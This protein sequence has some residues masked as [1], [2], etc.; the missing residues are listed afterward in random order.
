MKNNLFNI[1]FGLFTL[2]ILLFS[3]DINA[4]SSVSVYDELLREIK[5]NSYT[6]NLTAATVRR[7]SNTT[8]YTYTTHGVGRVD[9][10]RYASAVTATAQVAF[11]DRNK[12]KGKKDVQKLF[13][14][15]SGRTIVAY[16]SLESWGKS[17]EY[18]SD[19]Q[20]HKERYGYYL[21]GKYNNGFSSTRYAISFFK[22]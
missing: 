8:N 10:G 1:C 16:I 22:Q 19:I 5:T 2:T 11:S 21:T 9:G 6:M 4:Q 20:V 18:I 14:S 17:R 15:K 7:S 13:L 12:F 3:S